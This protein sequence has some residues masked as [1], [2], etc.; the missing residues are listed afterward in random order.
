MGVMQRGRTLVVAAVLALGGA[1]V[2]GES[3]GGTVTPTTIPMTIL[4]GPVVASGRP[5]LIVVRSK[6]PYLE[7]IDPAIDAVAWSMPFDLSYSTPGQPFEPPVADGVAL[8]LEPVGPGGAN[9]VR[10]RGV[11]VA[12]G[13][14][15]WTRSAR[16]VA[17]DDGA[18]CAPGVFCVSWVDEVNGKAATGLLEVDASTG[19]TLRD[20]PQVVRELGDRLYQTNAAQ[21]TLV[22]LSPTGAVKWKLSA[23]SIFGP[24]ADHPDDGWNVDRLGTLDVGSLG[25]APSANKLNYGDFQTTGFSVASGAS[26]WTDPGEYNCMGLTELLTDPVLCRFTGTLNVTSEATARAS[27]AKLQVSLVGFDESTGEVTWQ[28]AVTNARPF[29]G[30]SPIVFASSDSLVVDT[31]SGYRI[32]DVASGSLSAVPSQRTYWCVSTNPVT[33]TPPA[34]YASG[35]TREPTSRFVGCTDS[36]TTVSA[37]P[38][39]QPSIAGVDAGGRFFYASP[40]G[41][42]VE[43]AA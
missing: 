7:A 37:M 12:T 13:R 16:G 10:L 22:Q 28:Q 36:G 21:A 32:L 30:A 5:V 42:V 19:T 20:V 8:D 29:V 2:V 3:A 31:T 27:L 24:V 23:S 35:A 25:V 18:V 39:G 41:L 14:I 6:K 17:E 33:V 40:T 9:G 1:A 43:P 38:T 34:D 4:S 26:I 15:V 11:D